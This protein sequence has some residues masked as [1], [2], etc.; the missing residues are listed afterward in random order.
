MIM[1]QRGS[2]LYKAKLARQIGELRENGEMASDYSNY[3]RENYCPLEIGMGFA[4]FWFEIKTVIAFAH[5]GLKSGIVFEG[6]TW[7]CVNIFTDWFRMDK[8]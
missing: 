6:A 2:S 8:K 7:W 3:S 4:P 1:T 5:F